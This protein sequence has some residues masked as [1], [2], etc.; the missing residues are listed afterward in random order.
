MMNRFL[1]ALLASLCMVGCASISDRT[2]GV[3]VSGLNSPDKGFSYVI[4]D[5]NDPDHGAGGETVSPY[6]GGGVMCCY[7]LPPQWRPGIK[8][9]VKIYQYD[10]EKQGEKLVKEVLAEVPPYA[11]GK[12][13][14][15]WAVLYP[16]GSVE[17][18]SSDVMPDHPA[19]PGKV[20]GWPEPSI[21]YLR[22]LWEREVKAVEAD[23]KMYKNLMSQSSTKEGRKK[24]WEFD[25]KHYREETQKFSGSEDLSYIEWLKK[26]DEEGLLFSKK[27]LEALQRSKP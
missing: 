27:Q 6:G 22:F 21:E 13:G 19:W 9:L 11:K 2:S 23:I 25:R 18:I 7:G 15:L 20:K 16:D 17:A 5:P 8:V 24:R 4:R 1:V 14:T 26:S 10:Y 12:A 3:S